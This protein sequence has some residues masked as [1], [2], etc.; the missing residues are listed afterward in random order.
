VKST[1]KQESVEAAVSATEEKE[2]RVEAGA[3]TGGGIAATAEKLCQRANQTNRLKTKKSAG[4]SV[5]MAL[6]A[7]RDGLL[8]A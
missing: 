6:C 3:P 1:E 4:V 5:A 2:Q 8:L 7:V